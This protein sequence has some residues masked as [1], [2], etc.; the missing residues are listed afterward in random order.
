MDRFAHELQFALTAYIANG[1]RKVYTARIIN[2][3]DAMGTK[4]AYMRAW[5]ALSTAPALYMAATGKPA[6][7]DDKCDY[8]AYKVQRKAVEA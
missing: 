5:Y 8:A 1:N 3:A 2:A 4:E 7:E 6:R